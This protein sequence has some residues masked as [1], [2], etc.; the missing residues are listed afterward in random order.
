MMIKKLNLLGSNSDIVLYENGTVV[1]YLSNKKLKTIE[2]NGTIY[3]Y[4]MINDYP[5]SVN[6]SNALKVHFGNNLHNN[7][8]EVR[9]SKDILTNGRRLLDTKNYN[10][11]YIKDMQRYSPIELLNGEVIRE[12]EM[13]GTRYKNQYVTNF[14]RIIVQHGEIWFE[15]HIRNYKTYWNVSLTDE[16]G[17][18]KTFNIH[19]IVAHTFRKKQYEEMK[20]LYP[21]EKL[22]IDHIRMEVNS[23]DTRHN[24][25]ASNL[26]FVTKRQ[27]R[28]IERLRRLVKQGIE[29]DQ[30]FEN[31][32]VY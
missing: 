13:Y 27:H 6:I 15:E 26:Q 22:E 31:V 5:I 11:R 32:R 17:K 21:N 25:C 12:I 3:L 1:E 23:A 28:E 20:K 4:R 8:R 2:I 24:N 19:E 29:V 14:G 10:I 9:N 16:K 18:R 30:F 7:F